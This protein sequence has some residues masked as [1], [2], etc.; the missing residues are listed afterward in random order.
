MAVTATSTTRAIVT[1]ALRLCGVTAIDQDAE[2]E[3]ATAAL[4]QLNRM[5]KAWQG[6]DY[7]WTRDAMSVSLVAATAAYTLTNPARPLEILSARY[8]ST[9]GIETPMQEMT[10]GEY[11]DLPLKSTAGVPTSYMYD[12]RREQGVLYVWPVR[13]A[14]TTETLELTIKPEI[15]DLTTLNDPLDVPVEWYDAVVYNLADRCADLFGVSA[16]QKG[17]VQPRAQA[18]LQEARAQ[19]M[20]ESVF[21]GG[22]H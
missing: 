11:D 12:R 6:Y 13:A 8:K 2:A 7:F 17:L 14:A 3:Y 18:L 9:D 10:R 1:D 20:T 19:A 5:L 16:Q 21:F 4:H 15:E 22:D